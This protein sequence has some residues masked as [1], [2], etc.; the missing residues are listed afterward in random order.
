MLNISI[1]CIKRVLLLEFVFLHGECF[2]KQLFKNNQW[3]NVSVYFIMFGQLASYKRNLGGLLGLDVDM[4]RHWL[5][6]VGSGTRTEP[7]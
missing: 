5:Q 4:E 1:W 7:T 3:N 6:K 2:K